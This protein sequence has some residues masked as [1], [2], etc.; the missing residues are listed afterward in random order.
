MSVSGLGKDPVTIHFNDS[1][2][3]FTVGSTPYTLA[4]PDATIV[5]DPTATSATTVFDAATNSWETTAPMSLAG[6]TFLD[7]LAFQVPAGGF[8]G[9]TNPVTWS[10]IFISDTPGVGINWKWGTAVYTSFSADYATLGVKPVDDN[11]ASAYQNSDH[12]GTPEG[13]KSFV[14]GGARGGGGSNFTGSYSAT[15]SAQCTCGA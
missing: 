2:V 4:L 14:T 15:G 3:T 1:K 13:F 6:N 9:G 8:P 5:F 12:A 10:G 7:G 11:N